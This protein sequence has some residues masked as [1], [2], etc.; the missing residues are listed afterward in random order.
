VLDALGLVMRSVAILVL[1]VVATLVGSTPAH[2]AASGPPT[3]SADTEAEGDV[4]SFL[5]LTTCSP[6]FVRDNAYV[7]ARY[8]IVNG[9]LPPGLSLW[10]DGGPAAQID[11]KPTTPGVYHFTIVATDSL[12]GRASGRYTV[13]VFPRLVLPGGPLQPPAVL[14]AQY[15]A[16]VSA[17]GGKPPY[18]Y[19]LS[20]PGLAIDSATGAISGTAAVNGLSCGLQVGVTDA[21][22]VH[23]NAWYDVAVSDSSGHWIAVKCSARFSPSVRI[24]R[25]VDRRGV[26][27]PAWVSR[28]L[29]WTDPVLIKG[30]GLSN[31]VAVTFAGRRAAFS[32]DTDKRLTAFPPIGVRSGRISIVT[33]DGR[34]GS[35][36]TYTVG[37]GG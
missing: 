22:G 36:G 17:S 20:F 37:G 9:A 11:G 33:P 35:V 12:G 30:H 1:V 21:A 2:A 19:A 32:I 27:A 5:R 23:V 8:R 6:Y 28:P 10:G 16:N 18:T 26:P 13:E 7:P 24:D 25:R 14:G 15:S 4:G 34:S 31:V 29:V 3:C